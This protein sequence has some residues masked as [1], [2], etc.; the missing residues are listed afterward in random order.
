M[1]CHLPRYSERCYSW[2]TESDIETWIGTKI[3]RVIVEF[4]SR[5]HSSTNFVNPSMFL[6]YFTDCPKTNGLS[7]EF[8]SQLRPGLKWKAKN[9]LNP[10]I[11][12]GHEKS[13]DWQILAGNARSNWHST[14][15]RK[16]RQ[17]FTPLW[18][19][20]IITRKHCSGTRIKSNP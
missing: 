13:Q 1:P 2:C 8:F 12:L 3:F 15:L 14:R 20:M 19:F 18:Q 6:K 11:K 9:S 17:T 16:V 7:L 10:P 5:I 4:T